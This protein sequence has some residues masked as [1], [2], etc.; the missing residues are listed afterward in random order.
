MAILFWIKI[1]TLLRNV[2]PASNFKIIRLSPYCLSLII[3][4]QTTVYGMKAERTTN[5]RHFRATHCKAKCT[6][7]KLP[8]LGQ[9]HIE[10]Q[11][12]QPTQEGAAQVSVTHVFDNVSASWEAGHS[13][14]VLRL[15]SPPPG[16]VP[17]TVYCA[18]SFNKVNTLY[19]CTGHLNGPSAIAKDLIL[20]NGKYYENN[21][22]RM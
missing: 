20:S 13:S 2:G 5:Q 3:L 6:Y 16:S 11:A 19:G 22:S 10:T 1:F 21:L 4:R 7:R 15:L 14:T 9:A 18:Q 17:D 8:S 12:T